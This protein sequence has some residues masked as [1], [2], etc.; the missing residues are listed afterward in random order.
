[1]CIR[2]RTHLAPFVDVS[3]KKIAAEVEVEM[4]GLDVSAERKKGIVERCLRNEINRLSLIHI[5]H[6]IL[7]QHAAQRDQS[8]LFHRY[9]T[10]HTVLSSFSGS[11][12]PAARSFARIFLMCWV[13]AVSSAVPSMP[14][15]AS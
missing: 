12:T 11:G 2:D 13:T 1:M 15:T 3:R 4:E 6:Q 10:P 9:P 8:S 14:K 7:Q 5:S